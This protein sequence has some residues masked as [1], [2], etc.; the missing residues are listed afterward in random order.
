MTKYELIRLCKEGDKGAMEILYSTYSMRMMSI[1]RKYVSDKK[2]SEDILHDGFIVI[3]TNLEKLKDEN[4]FEFWMGSIMR[5]ISLKYLERLDLF[6]MLEEDID[7]IDVPDTN[8]I[9]T[10]EELNTIIEKLPNG[11]KTIFRLAVL[12][13]KSHKE[14]SKILG[15]TPSTSASQLYHAK[16]LLRKLITDYRTKYYALLIIFIAQF[17]YLHLDNIEDAHI[18]PKQTQ[19]V[20]QTNKAIHPNTVNVK[21]SKK[22]ELSNAL[23]RKQSHKEFDIAS[24]CVVPQSIYPDTLPSVS[25][26]SDACKDTTHTDEIGIT[27]SIKSPI[28]RSDKLL[29]LG[30]K[31]SQSNLNKKGWNI[32]MAY[33]TTYSNIT[34]SLSFNDNGIIS[35]QPLQTD[36][37]YDVPLT[38]GITLDRRLNSNISLSTGISLTYQKGYINYKLEDRDAKSDFHNYY[39]SIPI[40]I[41]YNMVNTKHFSG[42][43]PCKFGIDIPIGTRTHT[44]NPFYLNLPQQKEQTPQLFISSGI[45]IGY[46]VSERFDVYIEPSIKYYL[47]KSPEPSIW[48]GKRFEFN[49]PVG[50]RYSW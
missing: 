49:L 33:S 37:H 50:F 20:T 34:T 27:D 43:I 25:N 9:L 48:M 47:N 30:I 19:I 17:I 24:S 39:L 22:H 46:R 29:N 35:T 38:L 36:Y 1:I 45:G 14:I 8:D 44:S 23:K 32:S 12:E 31:Y 11:Y 10:Y 15:I 7:I 18:S 42:Y 5:N 13:N 41:N 26:I 6:S 4:S 16:V 40:G 3:F 21:I 28:K 2:A